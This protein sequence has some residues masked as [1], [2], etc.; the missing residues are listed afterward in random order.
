MKKNLL[1]LLLVSGTVLSAQ[2]KNNTHNLIAYFSLYGNQTSVLTD[3]DTSAS[4]TLY[5][6]KLCGN[7]ELLARVIQDK[8]GGDLVFV[9][10]ENKYSTDYN[11]VV[12]AG[13]SERRRGT[14]L[15][16]TNQP[17]DVSGYT[18]VFIVFPTWW[19]DLPMCLYTWIEEND[20]SGKNVYIVNTNGGYGRVSDYVKY[21][22]KKAP[23]ATVSE[24]ALSVQQRDIS[25]AEKTVTNWLSQ[26]GF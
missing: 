24:N 8:A 22:Q 7:A 18:S 2:E 26:I 5:K 25:Q 9:Q 1:L 16:I 21:V 11:T 19:Y 23:Q 17:M 4:R 10:A 12:D 13:S 6:D 14:H 15:P 3:A 20:L